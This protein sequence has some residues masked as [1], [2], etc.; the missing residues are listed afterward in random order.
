M[1]NC[2]SRSEAIR[3]A[4]G[5]SS[6]AVNGGRTARQPLSRANSETTRF[7]AGIIVVA[8]K[9]LRMVSACACN[10]S[11]SGWFHWVNT[12]WMP[13]GLTFTVAL[14][15]PAPP[16]ASAFDSYASLAGKTSKPPRA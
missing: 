4:A 9:I 11:P 3:D 15:Q 6:M 13:A 5:P 12:A 1:S 2:A 8:W 14:M 7:I 10:R 16:I